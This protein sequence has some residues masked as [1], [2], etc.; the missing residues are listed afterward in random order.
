MIEGKINQTKKWKTCLKPLAK[1]ETESSFIETGDLL[2]GSHD[3]EGGG[4]ERSC[5]KMGP[6]LGDHCCRRPPRVIEGERNRRLKKEV[7]GVQTSSRVC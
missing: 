4:E 6:S 2:W 7:K 3:R 1:I 5:G